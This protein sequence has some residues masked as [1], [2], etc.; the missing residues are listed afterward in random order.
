MAQFRD[1]NNE[2]MRRF[3]EVGSK[4]EAESHLSEVLEEVDQVKS[5]TVG[6]IPEPGDV[7]TINGLEWKV[8]R[9][10]SEITR[11]TLELI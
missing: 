9:A 8:V 1:E 5:G 4:E 11:I 3:T 10:S 6:E 2:L 7:I